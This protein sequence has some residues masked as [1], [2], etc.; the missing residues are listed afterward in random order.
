MTDLSNI[1][2]AVADTF[3]N[4]KD[5]PDPDWGVDVVAVTTRE[6]LV[7][8]STVRVHTAEGET[9]V[10]WLWKEHQ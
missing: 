3:N 6:A 10:V 7:A 8:A 9:F 1:T 5:D 2:K 4:I